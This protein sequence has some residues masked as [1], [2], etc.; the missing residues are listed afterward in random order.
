MLLHAK[1]SPES[2]SGLHSKK[3]QMLIEKILSGMLKRTK[4]LKNIM[5]WGAQ[6]QLLLPNLHSEANFCIPQKRKDT[7]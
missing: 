2:S 6:E 3:I 5:I 4:D 7:V 1:S